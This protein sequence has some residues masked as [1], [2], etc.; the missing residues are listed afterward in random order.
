MPLVYGDGFAL[1]M[2]FDILRKQNGGET[3]VYGIR[4]A[5]GKGNVVICAEM[6]NV[7]FTGGSANSLFVPGEKNLPFMVCRQIIR[8][9]E[10]ATNHYGCGITAESNEGRLRLVVTLPLAAPVGNMQNE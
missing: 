7:A 6:N 5:D 9:T 10:N 8:E 4:S 3:P 1:R 2:L